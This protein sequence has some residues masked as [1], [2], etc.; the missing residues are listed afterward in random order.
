MVTL[1]CAFGRTGVTHA[2]REG[3][4]ATPAGAMRVLRGFYRADRMTRPACAVPLR[5]VTRD[6]GWC[7]DP[8][9]PAYNRPGPLPMRASH[10]EMWRADGLYDVVFVLDYNLYPRRAGGGSAIFLHCA[11]EDG[12]ARGRGGLKPT[13]GCVALRGADMRRLL[14]RLGRGTR[15]VVV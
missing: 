10:E 11:R 2:K 15:V 12:G 4:G 14:P 7:D 6:L 8:A 9:S 1:A 13:L 3:D 5:P